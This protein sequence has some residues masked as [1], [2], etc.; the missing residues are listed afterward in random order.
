M[1]APIPWIGGPRQQA[2]PLELV[3]EADDVGRLDPQR[4]GQ[5]A[6]GDGPLGI[7]VVKDRELSPSQAALGEAST[8]APCGGARKPQE[9]KGAT[10]AQRRV[11]DVGR[12][13]GCCGRDRIHVTDSYSS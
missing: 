6:L 12:R 2:P 4:E 8:K 5:L 3:E 1:P 7:E 13:R 10:R 11:P 9:Q